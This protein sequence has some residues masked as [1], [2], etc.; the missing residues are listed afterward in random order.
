MYRK[1]K[2]TWSHNDINYI[3]KFKE[4]FPELNKLSSSELADRFSKLKVNFYIEEKVSTKKLIRA[5][6]PFAIILFI[7][8]IIFLPINFLI[9]GN[10]YYNNFE[11]SKIYNWFGQ[12]KLL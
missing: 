12:L 1:L 6:L 3:P 4:T 8:M 10:W 11:D 9:T 2:R 7:L 5:T